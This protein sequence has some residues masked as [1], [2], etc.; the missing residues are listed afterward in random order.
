MR[1][2]IYT[3]GPHTVAAAKVSDLGLGS[4]PG[5]PMT[6]ALPHPR[7]REKGNSESDHSEK[8]QQHAIEAPV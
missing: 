2:R 3:S 4:V 8:Q 7:L 6:L 5:R 1:W